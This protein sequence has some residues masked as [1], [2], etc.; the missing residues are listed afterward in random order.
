[1]VP[2]TVRSG[3]FGSQYGRAVAQAGKSLKLQEDKDG[4]VDP[5]SLNPAYFTVP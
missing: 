4:V 5:G 3:A 1:L 2:G